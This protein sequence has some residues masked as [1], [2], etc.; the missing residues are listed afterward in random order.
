MALVAAELKVAQARAACG[1]AL[2][3]ASAAAF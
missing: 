3:R 1:G 2:N